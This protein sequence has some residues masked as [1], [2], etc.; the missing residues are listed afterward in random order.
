[1]IRSTVRSALVG[2]STICASAPI[3]VVT[4][5]FVIVTLIYFQLLQAI[6]GSDL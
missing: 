2:L 5:T 6:R 3:E 4:A 1:M